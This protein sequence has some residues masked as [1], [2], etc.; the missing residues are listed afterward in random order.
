MKGLAFEP[1]V[2]GSYTAPN[3]KECVGK[4]DGFHIFRHFWVDVKGNSIYN[5]DII[6]TGNRLHE[7]CISFNGFH[8]QRYKLWN[9]KFKPSFCYSMSLITKPSKNRDGGVVEDAEVIGNIHQNPELLER[10]ASNS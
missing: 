1:S 9:G 10:L 3:F 2:R 8:L 5:G 7:V 6:S 4:R